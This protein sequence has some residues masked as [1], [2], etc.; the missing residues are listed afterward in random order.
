[1]RGKPAPFRR[2]MVDDIESGSFT[3]SLLRGAL[4]LPK[5]D[6][7]QWAPV[8]WAYFHQHAGEK[9][10][11][12][13]FFGWFSYALVLGDPATTY[14]MQRLFGTDPNPSFATG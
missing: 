6:L 8:A 11:T 13:K 5:V 2:S 9:I 1:M 7:K 3:H 10:Y 4:A 12:F 14:I